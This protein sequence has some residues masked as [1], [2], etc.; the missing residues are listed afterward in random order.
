M[1]FLR[2]CPRE[3][4]KSPMAKSSEWSPGPF[5]SE[6][7]RHPVI[8]SACRG[9]CPLPW[10]SLCPWPCSPSP[11]QS[12]A[13][14]VFLIVCAFFPQNFI[15]KPSSA[16]PTSNFLASV[17]DLSSRLCRRIFH[18]GFSQVTSGLTCL[19]RPVFSPL[20]LGPQSCSF[21][22][23]PAGGITACQA[24]LAGQGQ[25][26]SGP[27]PVHVLGHL[28]TSVHS[29]S[30]ASCPFHLPAVHTTDEKY[31]QSL[32]AGTGRGR[33]STKVTQRCNHLVVQML[34]TCH[35]WNRPPCEL[36]LCSRPLLATGH[37]VASPPETDLIKAP[38][39][40]TMSQSSHGRGGRRLTPW[41]GIQEPSQ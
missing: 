26:F 29:S 21:V 41:H 18:L 6:P 4:Y 33:L 14:L 17:S 19:W 10:A 2:G 12:E 28:L 30:F 9:S 35:L 7:G 36:S 13:V 8:L 27:L 11:V 24:F 3:S 31:S 32:A 1:S 15:H 34:D 16:A 22:F 20:L 39:S 5:L 37:S 38:S 40:R 25:P 23:V